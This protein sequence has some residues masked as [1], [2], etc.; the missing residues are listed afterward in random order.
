MALMRDMTRTPSALLLGL[1]VLVCSSLQS[2]SAQHSK[3][4][5]LSCGGDRIAKPGGGFWTCTFDD[6][7]TGHK[8]DTSQ[9]TVQQ[10]SNSSYYTG[11][12][13]S[14]ACYVNSPDNVSVSGGHLNLTARRESAPFTCSDPDGDYRTQFTSGMVSTKFGFHQ[15][16]GRFEFR[17][18]LPDTALNGVQETLWLWP[19]KQTYGEFPHSGEID[20]AEFYSQFATLDIPYIHYV[21]D[22]SNTNKA[23]NT[24]IVTAN[25]CSIDYRK[26]NTYTAV[27][28]PGTITLMFNGKTCLV[29]HYVPSGIASPAPFDQPFFIVLT[30][31]LSVTTN[32]FN[33]TTTPLPATIQ[34]DYVRAWK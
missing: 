18:R 15:T 23:M 28:E 6:E 16:Y 7:F 29:D 1:L 21:Y 8:L 4:L 14:R 12:T 20:V 3:H 2:S 10:T 32:A 19:V 5:R 27:W 25:A 33:P 22:P 17:A 26:F 31:A 13:E 9:W 30:Q 34:I 11:P 24:N